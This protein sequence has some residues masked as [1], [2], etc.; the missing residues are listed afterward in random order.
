VPAFTDLGQLLLSRASQQGLSGSG[1][2]R[3]QKA[4]SVVVSAAPLV[5]ADR[6][7]LWSSPS[8]IPIARAPMLIPFLVVLFNRSFQPH[9]EQRLEGRRWR[10]RGM[11]ASAKPDPA[12]SL[13]ILLGAIVVGLISAATATRR[14]SLLSCFPQL[15]ASPGKQTLAVWTWPPVGATDAG[16]M[17]IQLR[18]RVSLRC[19]ESVRSGAT[20]NTARPKNWLEGNSIAQAGVEESGKKDLFGSETEN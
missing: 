6:G 19:S 11:R 7:L 13:F 8:L 9:L 12:T 3:L 17:Q 18:E 15:I 1:K 10:L 14:A 16:A 4:A 2:P 20:R 5:R